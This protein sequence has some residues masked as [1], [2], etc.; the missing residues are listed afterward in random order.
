[1]G[2]VPH[3][4]MRA[5]TPLPAVKQSKGTASRASG[6]DRGFPQLLGALRS[7]PIPDDMSLRE[8]FEA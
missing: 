2:G 7:S 1:M 4:G 6:P 3:V 8:A 5:W